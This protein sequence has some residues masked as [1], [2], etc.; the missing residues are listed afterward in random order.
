MAILDS[1]KAIDLNYNFSGVIYTARSSY[2]KVCFDLKMMKRADK[3]YSEYKIPQS[4]KIIAFCKGNIPFAP[5]TIEGIV[6]TNRAAYY[7][8]PRKSETGIISNCL[9]YSSLGSYI[10]TQEGPKGIV[11]AQTLTDEIRLLGPSIVS[12]NIAG[13]EVRQILCKIQ[14]ELFRRNPVAKSEFDALASASIQKIKDEMGIEALSDRYNAILNSL[15]EYPNHA[16]SAAMV[17][18][19][20]LFR[21][22]KPEK[23]KDFTD[24]LP[25]QVS[26]DV[27]SRIANIPSTFVDNYIGLL[28]DV[29][30]DFTYRSLSEV[31]KQLG[32]TY[33]TD[34]TTDILRT[35]VC[36]RMNEYDWTRDHISHLRQN[37]GTEVTTPIEW[38]HCLFAYHE[39]QKVYDAIKCQKD[40]PTACTRYR[41]GLGLT[42]LHYAIILKDEKAMAFL[43]E[44]CDWKIASPYPALE[45]FTKMYEYIVPACGKQLSNLESILLKTHNETI[46]L[47]NMIKNLEGKLKFQNVVYELQDL[48]MFSQKANYVHR[49]MHRASQDELNALSTKMATLKENMARAS[50]NAESLLD[51]LKECEQELVCV[52][53]RSITEALEIMEEVK[54]SKDPISRYLYRIYFEPGFFEQVLLAVKEKQGLGLYKYKHFYFAAPDFAE[55]NLPHKTYSGTKKKIKVN[56]KKSAPSDQPLYGSSWFSFNA[57]HDKEQLKAEYHKLAKLYH[58]D[59]SKHPNGSKLFQHI[60]EEY[61]SILNSISYNEN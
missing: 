24:S 15:M 3:V 18:A 10:I 6:F 29:D 57:H 56:V 4:E 45:P 52:M 48:S 7:Y 44:H 49:T 19:E 51:M 1:E 26:S 59:V 9:L 5:L 37:Y 13:A 43:L 11:F 58:P 17:K 54:Q 25:K 35:Y 27:R 40:L 20:Y 22:F 16:D 39:M 46:Q 14:Q 31:Y 33:R 53:E 32:S 30:R 42:P 47:R 50:D 36:I 34:K 2:K 28:T 41:D 55:I 21:E 38:F 12:Q 61:Q 8:P 23:Y 60:S